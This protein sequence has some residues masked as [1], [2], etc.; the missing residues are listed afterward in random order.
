MQSLD[1]TEAYLYVPILPLHWQYLRFQYVGHH[2]QYRALPFGLSSVPRTFTKLLAA[3]V[4]HL[5]ALPVRVQC[6][7]ANILI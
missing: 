5:W 7:L 3:L 4:A 6:Y 2:Y 1:L